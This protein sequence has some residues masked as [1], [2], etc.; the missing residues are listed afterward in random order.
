M[1]VP[2]RM[3]EFD[4]GALVRALLACA[5]RVRYGILISELGSGSVETCVF[6]SEEA[7]ELC[8]GK[9]D[10]IG[11]GGAVPLWF[12]GMRFVAH[13]PV[14]EGPASEAAPSLQ[15]EISGTLLGA[16]GERRPVVWRAVVVKH[17]GFSRRVH[18]LIPRD[19][20]ARAEHACQKAHDSV[21]RFVAA[22][23]EPVLIVDSEQVRMAN[24]AARALF[25]FDA[26][27]LPDLLTLAKHLHDESPSR[28]MTVIGEALSGCGCVT[29]RWPLRASQGFVRR[30]GWQLL[31]MVQDE[32]PAVLLLVATAVTPKEPRA[33]DKSRANLF[34]LGTLTAGVAHEINNPL[35]YI[36]LNIHSLKRELAKNRHTPERLA[37]LAERLLDAQHGAERVRNIVR[38]LRLLSRSDDEQL[39]PVDLCAVLERALL[40]IAPHIPSGVRIER[41]L[42]A[43]PPV[44]GHSGRLEQVFVNL[45][46]NACQALGESPGGGTI[47]IVVQES[48]NPALPVAIR[49]VDDGPG[50]RREHLAHVFD[51]FF[52]TK[53]VGSGTGLGLPISHG[54]VTRLGGAI[55]VESEPT[56]GTT[57][58]VSLPA[59]PPGLVLPVPLRVPLASPFPSRR[60]RILVIDD[61]IAVADVLARILADDFDVEITTDT[62]RAYL[63]L[64]DGEVDLALCDLLMPEV[65]GMDLYEQLL[66]RGGGLEDRLIFMTGGAFTQ[67]A[68]QFLARVKNPRIEKPF[69]L[70]D[71]RRLVREYG[72]EHNRVVVPE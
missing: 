49:I 9:V 34:E 1:A 20:E 23:T 68:A 65:T 16:D 14:I 59:V 66:A 56:V 25:G 18:L 55:G 29:D 51:P 61:E 71:V 43:V 8:Q 26:E 50:I 37:G 72:R 60:L 10:R 12:G 4:E 48:G 53:P 44:L 36:L 54:I 67:R 52:T 58:T 5:D 35:S 45:L 19:R 64:A 7:E 41:D 42:G 63:A 24:A 13:D 62:E 22:A 31:P 6:A 21:V 33:S 28:A 27:G 47:R 2:L 46:F 70:D 30:I 11:F 39:A 15:S 32:R 40:V 38:D 17:A 3:S 69:D 57:F